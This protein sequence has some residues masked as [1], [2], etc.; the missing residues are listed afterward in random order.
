MQ[1]EVASLETAQQQKQV[2]LDLF[3]S[4]S[5]RL[6][7]DMDVPLR[8]KQGQVEMEPQGMVDGN[9]DLALL[10]SESLIRVCYIRPDTC[11]PKHDLHSSHRYANIV[12][13]KILHGKTDGPSFSDN[14][15]VQVDCCAGLLPMSLAVCSCFEHCIAVN[16]NM[17]C[18]SPE[19]CWA[20]K[21]LLIS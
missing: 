11:T 16:L 20:V 5:A 12:P 8:L 1:A 13:V 21:L 14:W 18:T 4:E 9:L 3:Q 2:Q 6:E 17:V 19:H 15:S 7:A 10:V